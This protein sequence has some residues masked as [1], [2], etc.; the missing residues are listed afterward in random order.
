M[1]D[2]PD[3][4][5]APDASGASSDP[6]AVATR[7]LDKLRAFIATL[8]DDE[9]ATLAALLAPGVAS[10]YRDEADDEPEVV[11]FSAEMAP[12]EVS[13]RPERLGESLASK[14]RNRSLRI[15]EG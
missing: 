11:G 3:A 13:W 5:E 12:P 4:P 14:V 9:R 1:T 15:E 7:V 6:D 10:A 2:S 8:D